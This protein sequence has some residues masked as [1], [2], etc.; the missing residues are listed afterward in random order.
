MALQPLVEQCPQ[1]ALAIHWRHLGN[2]NA[3]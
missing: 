3:R 1:W 2:K